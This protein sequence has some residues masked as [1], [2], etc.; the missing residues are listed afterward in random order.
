MVQLAL[1]V[2]LAYV[3]PIY[4]KWQLTQVGRFIK[5]KVLHIFGAI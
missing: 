1:T 2:V 3:E 4:N 5:L